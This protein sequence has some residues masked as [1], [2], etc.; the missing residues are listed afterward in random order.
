[1]PGPRAIAV[2]FTLLLL[3]SV[4]LRTQEAPAPHGPAPPA[5]VQPLPYSHKKH[6]AF[7][8]DCRTCHV[9]PD[10]GKLMTFP[11]TAFCMGCHQ[12]IAADRPPIKQLAAFAA[13]GKPVPWIR[14]Y[15]LPDY[16]FWKHATHL[17]AG[18]TCAECHGPVA[19]RD[20]MA[21]ETNVVTMV[22]CLACHDKR[23]VF[24]DCAACHDPR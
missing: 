8:L 24:T 16:V 4:T 12:G 7:G 14:V 22:G 6:V 19:E 2:L 9:N 20:V 3:T 15:R 18:V 13:S 11:P 23:Q 5:P 10:P 1:M 17:R 21:Q